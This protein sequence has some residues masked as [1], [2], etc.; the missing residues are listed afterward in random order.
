MLP[1][2]SEQHHPSPQ[3]HVAIVV[4]QT[5]HSALGSGFRSALKLLQ[6]GQCRDLVLIAE[7]RAGQRGQGKRVLGGGGY[8]T[9]PTSWPAPSWSEEGEG[10]EICHD[11]GV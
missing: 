2:H 10:G 1:S 3:E 11:H 9:L 8:V 6:Q 7:A 4:S 5:L